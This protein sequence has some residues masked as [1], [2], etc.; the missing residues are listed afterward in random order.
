VRFLL[1]TNVLSEAAR[2]APNAGVV[3]WLAAQSPLDLAL[4]ALSIGEIEKGISLLAP[5]KRRSQLEAWLAVELPRRFSG[6]VLPID[7]GVAR[8]WGRLSGEAQRQG[9]PLP[10][11]DGLLLATASVQQLTLVTRNV[12]DCQDRGVPVLSPWT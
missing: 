6:R 2:P 11:V 9:R 4:S 12:E 10:V 1:D 5:G 7:D 3:T 8:K